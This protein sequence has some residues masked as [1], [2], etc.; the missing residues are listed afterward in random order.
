MSIFSNNDRVDIKFLS[1]NFDFINL[2]LFCQSPSFP[3]INNLPKVEISSNTKVN[4]HI[5][6]DLR[7]LLI[8]Y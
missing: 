7:D 3:I 8:F 6:F 2:S 5:F 1:Q 4:D